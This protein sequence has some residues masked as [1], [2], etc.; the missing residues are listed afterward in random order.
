MVEQ[1]QQPRSPTLAALSL[2]CI[3]TWIVGVAVTLVESIRDASAS[4]V[5]E[6]LDFPPSSASADVFWTSMTVA[7]VI[8]SLQVAS[9][10]VAP[11]ADVRGRRL[12]LALVIWQGIWL[13]ALVA[14]VVL[15]LIFHN[16]VTALLVGF[17]GAVL[18]TL[19]NLPGIG[20]RQ[21]QQRSP[22]IATLA[23]LSLAGWLAMYG[24]DWYARVYPI[25]CGGDGLCMDLLG[26]AYL[27]V[28]TG[29]LIGFAAWLGATVRAVRRREVLSAL[30]IGL[31]LP[32]ALGNALLV[33]R[34]AIGSVG[35]VAAW[36][37]FSVVAVTLLAT[38]VTRRPTT[39][40]LVAVAGL[41]LA[42]ALLVVGGLVD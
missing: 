22:V 13:G 1:H 25:S 4:P 34:H 40:R 39:R 5:F 33:N 24:L 32:V 37:V 29:A 19:I 18:F 14:E 11:R 15:D 27:F 41:A 6:T 10:R 16:D 17:L 42:V 7:I 35:Y 2:L 12:A 21:Q 9:Q 31:L 26:P 20:A 3:G 8:T 38:S 28:G 36:A 23:A 30:S